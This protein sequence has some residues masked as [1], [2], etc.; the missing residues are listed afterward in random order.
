MASILLLEDDF[1]LTQ[2]YTEALVKVGHQVDFQPNATEAFSRCKSIRFDVAVVDIFISGM[3]GF[4][5]DGGLSFISKF[6]HYLGHDL[7]TSKKMPIIAISG[8]VSVSTQFNPLGTALDIGANFSIAKPFE[9]STLVE[10]VDQAL[11][12]FGS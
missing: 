2:D 12:Q 9:V 6:R 3:D 10:T 11:A 4:V 7:K 8:G 5:P 1:V